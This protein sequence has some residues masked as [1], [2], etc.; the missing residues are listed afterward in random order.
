MDYTF[1]FLIFLN[2]K[3]EKLLAPTFLN[4]PKSKNIQINFLKTFEEPKVF[5]KKQAKDQWFY[6]K[7]LG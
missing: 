7:L 3:I 4:K 5:M 6:G 2:L 1:V